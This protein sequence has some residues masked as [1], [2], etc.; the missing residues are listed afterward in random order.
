MDSLSLDLPS[1]RALEALLIEQHVSRAA[2]RIHLSQPAMSRTLQRLRKA[3]GDELLVRTGGRYELTAKAS[4]LLPRVR[5]ILDD[6]KA[7]QQPQDFSP[8]RISDQITVAGLD[9]ELQL[10][11]PLLLERLR[12]EAPHATL[13]L[14][15]FSAGD[16]QI[17]E[18]EEVDFVITAFPCSNPHYRRRLLYTNEFACVMNSR[19]A[20]RISQDFNLEHFVA[21][22]HGLVSFEDQGKGQVDELLR[23]QGL[24]RRIVV[25]VPGFALV[26]G[27][28]ASRDVLFTLPTRTA[29]IFS[30]TPKLVWLPAPFSLQPTNTFV[31][32]HPRNHLNPLHQWFR[33]IVFECSD[34]IDTD[35]ARHGVIG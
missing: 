28:C 19:L 17:L 9:F 3:L 7:L 29:R 27:V 21:L 11:V 20:G 31:V 1:L 30:R 10:F 6:V 32:W 23:A 15:N 24:S 5:R 18:T 13:R 14:L 2:R 4:N 34:R 8:E 16:F 25:R 22:E 33:R 26:P 35:A 12:R